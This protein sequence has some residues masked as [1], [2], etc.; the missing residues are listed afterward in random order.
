MYHDKTA[1]RCVHMGSIFLWIS[2]ASIFFAHKRDVD[3]SLQRLLFIYEV[4][5]D[6]SITEKL[7][8]VQ[9]KLWTTT[10][11]ILFNNTRQQLLNTK[12]GGRN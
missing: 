10:G 11:E 3:V 12:L 7:A 4:N 1:W 8:Y 5:S 6:F 2:F 9:N